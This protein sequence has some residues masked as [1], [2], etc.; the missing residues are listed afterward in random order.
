MVLNSVNSRDAS[1]E[2]EEHPVFV[3][4]MGV[5]VG[6]SVLVVTRELRVELHFARLMVVVEGVSS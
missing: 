3:L 1:R 5:V 2:Q 6:A 4:L